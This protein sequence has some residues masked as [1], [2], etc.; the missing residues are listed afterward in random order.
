MFTLTLNSIVTHRRRF[1]ATCS[2]VVLGVAFLAGT[3]M[4]GDTMQQ[5]FD[6]VF[7]TANAGTDVVVR[8]AGSIGS[9]DTA[10]RAGL[11]STLVSTI[12]AVPGVATATPQITGIA[13]L[14]GHDGEPL[15]GQGP[16]TFGGNWIDGSVNPF[17]LRE[18]RAPS[19]VGE[20]VIDQGSATTGKL[21]V[22]DHT[23]VRTPEPTEVT[24]V[25]I[26][27]FGDAETMGGATYTLFTTDQARSLLLPGR[28]EV[29]AIVA[30]AADGVSPSELSGRIGSMLPPGA[31]AL[32]GAQL[33]SE[34]VASIG[35]EFL[36]FLKAF[37]LVFSGVAMLVATFSI[38]NT[39]AVVLSQR[40]SESALLRALGATR[41]Q[42][43]GSVLTETV[44]VG[45]VAAGVG[46]VAGLGLAVGLDKLLHA[47]GLG[48]PTAGLV[49]EPRSLWI[50]AV[51]GILATVLAG[52]VP[53]ITS[54]RVAPL[55]ALRSVAVDRSDG[56]RG[57]LAGGLT[58]F[59]GGLA[60]MGGPALGWWSA[61]LALVGLGAV[62]II[63][64]TVMLGPVIARPVSAAL[65][66][67]LVRLRGVTGALARENAMRNPKRTAGTASALMVGVGVVTLFIVFGTSIT[68]SLDASI[69][70]SVRAELALHASGSDETGLPAELP[71][72]LSTVAGVQQV[73][74]L[75]QATAA[76]DGTST[77][78]TVADFSHLGSVLDLGS[79]SIDL[80]TLGIDDLA[81][82]RRT[83]TERNWQVGS[84]VP[85]RF[86][87][88]QTSTLRVGAIFD[89]T[90]IVDDVIISKAAWAPHT[91]Q[92]SFDLV[93]VKL[94][95]GTD[96]APATADIDAVAGP[97]GASHALDRAGFVDEAAGRI[98]T[99][100]NVVYVLLALSILIALMGIANTLSL[101][102][103]E[104]TRE[105]GLLRAVGETRAQ[106]R[107]MV[108][109]EAM[110]ISVFGALAGIALGLLCGW[111]LVRAAGSETGIDVFAAPIG[112]LLIVL[113]V[114][115]AVGGIASIRPASRAARL[116]VL[117]ALTAA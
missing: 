107:S 77:D 55:A 116:D 12:A 94:L 34:Q 115:A 71:D 28:D 89:H 102:I 31:E 14:I 101:S 56:S 1:L 37:L 8:S 105:L 44:I 90:N 7:S 22:G 87:D 20:V 24:V 65:G 103:H 66:L 95:P 48:V 40:T 64:G 80:A 15:G 117:G 81:V 110:L 61:P 54:S 47:L 93:L 3:L 38:H 18:G 82:S 97:L 79:G 49:V 86:G 92:P 112:R 43:L 109:W 6:Q 73:T 58:L 59:L 113:L 91:T 67:P 30:S 52:V 36:D 2:A 5:G 33:T 70:G 108:R 51:V 27:T 13:Q 114:G 60:L 9:D 42:V 11:P 88:G 57:R 25:G 75:G 111:G 21:A 50:S 69:A 26:A 46:L 53:A 62:G 19:R 41:R 106:T 29:T 10:Q 98:G 63:V 16:P 32:T 100:L 17:R 35:T 96:M 45:V 23:T 39:F 85:A 78:L 83:A 68:A 84:T 104:R 76:L 74:G 99:I 72:R 4:L